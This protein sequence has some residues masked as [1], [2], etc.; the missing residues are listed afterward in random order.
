MQNNFTFDDENNSI[1]TILSKRKLRNNLYIFTYDKIEI[2]HFDIQRGVFVTRDGKEYK[3]INNPE[4]NKSTSNK[5]FATCLDK[6]D[7]ELVFSYNNNCHN[8][9]LIN[10]YRDYVKSI[11]YL[12]KTGKNSFG[13]E[14]VYVQDVSLD[15]IE[16]ALS[17]IGSFAVSNDKSFVDDVFIGKD[18]IDKFINKDAIDSLPISDDV[19]KLIMDVYNCEFNSKELF[20]IAENIFFLK[21]YLQCALETIELQL[22]AYYNGDKA[23][24]YPDKSDYEFINSDYDP[25]G[26]FL[27]DKYLS[28]KE[29]VPPEEVKD[30]LDLI[31]IRD[32]IKKHLIN[33]DEALRRVLVEIAR[34]DVKKNEK[35]KGILLLGESGTGKTYLMELLAEN[36]GVPFLIIDSTQLTIP[37]YVGKDIQEYLWDLYIK[38]DRD[39][40]KAESA[41]VF[42]DEIDKKGSNR[43]SDSSG[44]GVLNV[45]LKFLDGTTYDACM[46][47]RH[48]TEIVKMNTGKMKI[49]AGGAFSDVLN[50]KENKR[51]LGFSVGDEEE[52]EEKDLN[53]P[54]VDD[55]VQKAFMTPEFMGRFP[56]RIRLNSHSVE[57]FATI[58]NESESSTLKEEERTFKKLGVKLSVT[59][60][61]VELACSEALKL[62]T[63][64]R[65]LMGT[66]E[67]S[68]WIAFEDA[69]NNPGKYSEII[70]T[71]DTLK[72][73]NNYQ[74]VLKK[75][76]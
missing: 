31:K 4:F 39:L 25:H 18:R 58:L 67:E 52:E 57:S 33:Q 32:D 21:D 3:S 66:I 48:S 41:I 68:T 7:L 26:D 5:V 38:C 69:Y 28:K 24:N 51:R 49:I 72:D 73:P 40:E 60:K 29:E 15:K 54:G 76:V 63:G 12:A 19:G 62:K 45:L 14:C 10:K 8:K 16:E 20:S 42:F 13:R 71:E 56:I 37:G 30:R 22:E 35:N 23:P 2:G 75:E 65:G 64:V 34:M 36:L 53:I 59:P 11:M 55:F 74:K 46:D 17:S 50:V 44:Q 6:N 9:S 61:F 70:L 27:N 47:T 43:K 1:A